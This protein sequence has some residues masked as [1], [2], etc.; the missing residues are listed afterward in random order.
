M[1]LEIETSCG[2]CASTNNYFLVPLALSPY[3]MVET[4]NKI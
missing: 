2:L 3:T 4:W 1:H